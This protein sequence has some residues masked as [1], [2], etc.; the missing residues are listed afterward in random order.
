MPLGDQLPRAFRD[1][2][3]RSGPVTVR[4]TMDEIW[5]PKLLAPAFWL[6]GKAGILVSSTGGAIPT[7]L[8]IIPAHDAEGRAYQHWNR[9]FEMPGGARQQFDTRVVWDESLNCAADVVGVGDVLY[10]AWSITFTPPN[11]LSIRREGSAIRLWGRLV[12]LPVWLWKLALGRETFRQWADGER[13][14]RIELAV[15]HP[16]LGRVFIYR[17]RFEVSTAAEE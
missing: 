2:F 17:G 15:D 4:G 10:L 1:Q 11:T 12:W 14:I 8:E 16:L 5:Y 13:T 6:L 7:L 9:T 3:L